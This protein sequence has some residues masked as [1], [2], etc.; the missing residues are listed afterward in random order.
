[1]QAAGFENFLDLLSMETRL[2]LF[3]LSA[4]QLQGLLPNISHM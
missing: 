4:P 1:M 3:I 2:T